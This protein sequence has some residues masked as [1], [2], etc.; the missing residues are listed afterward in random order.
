MKRTKKI[1]LIMLAVM[2]MAVCFIFGTSAVSFDDYVN[3]GVVN[4]ENQTVYRCYLN[5]CSISNPTVPVYDF[6]SGE[7][8]NKSTSEITEYYD[9]VP[10]NCSDYASFPYLE[11]PDSLYSFG[12]KR[13]DNNES[14]EKN[15]YYVKDSD[16][17]KIVEFVADV[18]LK[19]VEGNF[20]YIVTDG[21]ATIVK[22][23]GFDDGKVIIPDTLGGYEVAEIQ[24]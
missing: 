11:V 9:V 6:E 8:V 12:W 2:L 5:G 23:K 3:A 4:A 14:F 15:S 18:Q 24:R 22:V 20:S 17:G 10:L 21:K 16:A 13:V 1:A 7:F 19:Y